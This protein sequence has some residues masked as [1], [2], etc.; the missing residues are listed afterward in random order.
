MRSTNKACRTFVTTV[1]LLFLGITGL[2]WNARSAPPAAAGGQ[3]T[4]PARQQECRSLLPDGK[5]GVWTVSVM[6]E[7]EPTANDS[8]QKVVLGRFD[9]K[10]WQPVEDVTE[11]GTVYFPA[12]AGGGKNVW[13]AYAQ[14]QRFS[15]DVFVRPFD[16]ENLGEEARLTMH[17]GTELRPAIAVGE[18]RVVVVW[19][20]ARDGTG[21]DIVASV[22]DG[23]H[24]SSE[25]TVV[26][27]PQ[28]E[29]RPAL[30]VDS[31]GVFWCAFDRFTGTDYDVFITSSRDGVKWSDPMPLMNSA[32]DEMSPSI[33]ADRSGNVWVMANNRVVGVNER[34]R[35]ALAA[36]VT[37]A[38]GAGPNWRME[39]TT[40]AQGRLW[41][42]AQRPQ[43]G[44]RQPQQP[45]L[46]RIGIISGGEVLRVSE[47]NANLLGYRPPLVDGASVWFANA[48]NVRKV[49]LTAPQTD[50][51]S[52]IAAP[53]LPQKAAAPRDADAGRGRSVTGGGEKLNLYFGELHTHLTERPADSH[54]LTWVDRYYL[55]AR[56]AQGLDIASVSDH[57]WP[58]MTAS[59]YLV[60]QGI[61]EALNEPGK[62]IAFNGFEWSGHGPTRFRY[63]DRTVV[64]PRAFIDVPRITD[65][66]SDTPQKLHEKLLE[67]GA[68]DWPHHVSAPWAVMD[69]M[70]WNPKM[71]PVV[72]MTSSHGVYETYDPQ[73]KVP[74]N[75]GRVPKQSHENDNVDKTSIHY[76]LAQGYKFALV[77]SSDSHSG[78][79]GYRTGMLAVFAKDLT[80]ESIFEA[81]R[82]R[83]AYALRGGQRIFVDFRINGAFMGGEVTTKDPPKISAEIVGTQPIERVDVI[84]NNEFIYTHKP[85]PTSQQTT[86]SYV[87]NAPVRGQAYYY[88]RVWQ[89]GGAWA[90][91]A[92]IW[93]KYE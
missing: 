9:G 28:H 34:G 6:T 19:D 79:S 92:P 70:T 58:E 63:G 22:Y 48:N 36:N 39:M 71:E 4:N 82:H 51:P 11:P 25:V 83:R 59:K 78:I 17:P 38:L 74:V 21:F 7:G 84:R 56:H 1:V 93:V 30:A 47:V 90:W 8:N 55:K 62:F 80:R 20:A 86:L 61:C 65:A 57:D 16:G 49:E 31:K 10:Q 27:T 76:G 88:L 5:G 2:V 18:K 67:V 91:S 69:W 32:G 45:P 75:F 23:R 72:E 41:F 60:E 42:F 3:P 66:E 15:W 64:F 13:V 37:Q 14:L 40:D 46:T 81:W 89:E 43:G 52:V 68:I 35:V 53:P 73:K 87:D 77:G 54:I 29:F 12:I 26:S 50:A 44:Q 33:A 24:W 85:Q